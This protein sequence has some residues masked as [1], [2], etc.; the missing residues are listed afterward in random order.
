MRKSLASLRQ[1]AKQTGIP[2]ST[3]HDRMT[4]PET[5][6][7]AKGRKEVVLRDGVILVASDF[8]YWP[9]KPSTAHRAFIR[10]CKKLRPAVIVANGDVFDGCSI[11]RHPP[12]NWNKLPTVKEELEVCQER[13]S[14]I[15]KAAPKARRLWGLGNHDARF[16]VK[17]AQVAPE[18]KDVHGVSLSDHFPDWEP[19]WA[20][21]V[22]D[23]TVIKHR[24]KGGSHAPYNNTVSAGRSIITGHLHSQKV[25]PFTDYNGTRY[26]VDT[27]CLADP[28]HDAFQDYLEDGPRDWRSGFC[29]LTYRQGI[30]LYPELVSVF[31]ADHVQFRGEIIPV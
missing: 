8:H 30:L 21:H 28:Y 24:Y 17:L 4:H 5:G 25:T 12:I 19:C 1:L 9:G 2:K 18:F 16:E 6:A 10:F 15:V 23:N 26:G 14:E 11:S 22:N 31:D 7:K 29:V 13:L 27:G 20:V 3:I